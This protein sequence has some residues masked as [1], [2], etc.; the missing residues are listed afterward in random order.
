MN[1]PTN[2]KLRVFSHSNV[3]LRLKAC[4]T[5]PHGF[6]SAYG[7]ANKTYSIEDARYRTTH[8]C[9]PRITRP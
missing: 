1:R 4:V 9:T 5:Y 2:L 6:T 8:T 3:R 7:K